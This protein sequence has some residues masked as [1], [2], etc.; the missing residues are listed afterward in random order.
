M[1][2]EIEQIILYQQINESLI[3]QFMKQCPPFPEKTIIRDKNIILM[4]F[5]KWYDFWDS[6]DPIIKDLNINN[7][8]TMLLLIKKKVCSNR[9]VT[10]LKELKALDFIKSSLKII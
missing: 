10:L 1:R 8:K 3:K 2:S 4:E 7:R 5:Q 6:K 9:K